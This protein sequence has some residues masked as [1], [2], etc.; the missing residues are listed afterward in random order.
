MRLPS[1]DAID[2]ALAEKSLSQFVRQAWHVLE[3]ATDF[4][5]GWHID[6]ICE[7]L[8]AVTNGQIKNLI[9][10]IPPGCMKSL[11]TS[12]MWPVW[13]WIAHPHR[14]YLTASYAQSL[15]TRDALKSR[16]LIQSEWYQQRWGDCFALTSDQNQKT[17]YENNKAGFRVALSVGGA[18]TV[19][20]YTPDGWRVVI[21][22]AEAQKANGV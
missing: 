22:V 16:R 9:I 19:E 20:N 12:V 7:H 4:V 13:D 3:P 2:T 1:L 15:S 10:N 6:V 17:R 8:E 5:H 14:R 11:L 18:V 21:V